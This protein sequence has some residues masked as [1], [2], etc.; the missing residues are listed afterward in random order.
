MFLAF[1]DIC[2]VCTNNHYSSPCG[3]CVFLFLIASVVVVSA[4]ILLP[5]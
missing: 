3:V 4:D 2:I 1:R 5:V